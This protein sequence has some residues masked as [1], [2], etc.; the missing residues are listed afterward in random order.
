MYIYT[1][2]YADK[3]EAELSS[4]GAGKEGLAGTGRTVEQGS[5]THSDWTL[6]VQLGI[7]QINITQKFIADLR[8]K[9]Q[10]FSVIFLHTMYN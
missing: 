8:E 1:Y 6:T 9:T 4:D 7:L 3:V 2:L 5:A 10:F